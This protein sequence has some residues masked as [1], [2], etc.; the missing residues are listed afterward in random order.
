[1]FGRRNIP[2]QP[3]HG[4]EAPGIRYLYWGLTGARFG[5]SAKS[6][7]TEVEPKPQGLTRHLAWAQWDDA[8]PDLIVPDQ[9]E[10]SPAE[11]ADNSD[12]LPDSPRHLEETIARLT[13]ERDA[14]RYERE[15][16]ADYRE[17]LVRT[18]DM[19][20]GQ[21]DEAQRRLMAL[22]PDASYMD[23]PSGASSHEAQL[24]KQLADATKRIVELEAT[25]ATNTAESAVATKTPIPASQQDDMMDIFLQFVGTQDRPDD[26][27]L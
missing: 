19:L 6:A 22:D 12:H 3:T 9:N 13:A 21:L 10:E 15:L 26:A 25:I 18:V 24:E 16:E 8:P 5:R 27:R 14:A 7:R 11:P 20:R 1:M 4:N 2:A 23:D 17:A